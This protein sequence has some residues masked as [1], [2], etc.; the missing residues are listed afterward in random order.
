[1]KMNSLTVG[2]TI[3]MAAG[4]LSLDPSRLH[5]GAFVN[6]DAAAHANNAFAADLYGELSSGD[7]NLCFSPYSIAQ[8]FGMVAAGARGETRVGISWSG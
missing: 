5:A 3:M 1:M 8:A 4:F 6:L 2:S 7:G